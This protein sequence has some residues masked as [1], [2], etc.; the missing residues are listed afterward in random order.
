MTDAEYAS[1]TSGDP[2]YTFSYPQSNWVSTFNTTIVTRR[3]GAPIDKRQNTVECFRDG[4]GQFRYSTKD[5]Y[6]TYDAALIEKLKTMQRIIRI[7]SLDPLSYE[8]NVRKLQD[9]LTLI[10]NADPL[11][12]LLG[13]H[14]ELLL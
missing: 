9:K 5:V 2:V 6:M 14:P 1:L 10:M 12:T 4:G 13:L 11:L 8:V 3:I 7:K